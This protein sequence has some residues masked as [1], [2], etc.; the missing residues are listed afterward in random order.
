MNIESWK[1][2]WEINNIG[3]HKSKPHPF[4]VKHFK[5]LDLQDGCRVFVPLC[6]KSL[7]IGWLL[8]MGYEVAGV[9]VSQLAIE[10]LFAELGVK[11]TISTSGKFILYSARNIDI[12]VGDVFDL[13]NDILG[14]VDAIY[15]RAALVALPLEIRKQYTRHLVRIT[16][17]AD[18]LLITFEYDQSLKKGPPFSV[19]GD[20]IS[21][22]F[23]NSYLFSLLERFP[24]PGGLQG[25]STA[26]EC[27]WLLKKEDK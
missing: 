22:H 19:E 10:Q 6:G 4:L 12:F 25:S 11:P 26:N 13:S 16:D 17:S 5:E 1:Q 2:A 3:F 27:I 8:S 21:L 24:L 14:E 23:E 7:D 9:E 15:D 20:E 18:Q